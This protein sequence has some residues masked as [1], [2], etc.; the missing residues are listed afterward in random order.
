[1]GYELETFI[2]FKSSGIL[3][4]Q[5]KS[6]QNKRRRL[7]RFAWPAEAAAHQVDLRHHGQLVIHPVHDKV[8]VTI[9]SETLVK[10]SQIIDR[11]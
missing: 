8:V 3:D 10:V 7:R 5:V 1:M 9:Q 4:F 2:N 6:D 11:K